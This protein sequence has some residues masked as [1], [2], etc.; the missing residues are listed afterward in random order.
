MRADS[1]SRCRKDFDKSV[2]A[3]KSVIPRWWIQR[4]TWR[5]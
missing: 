4:I 2:I 1:I 5:A 3:S